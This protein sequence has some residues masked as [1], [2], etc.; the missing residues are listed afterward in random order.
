MEEFITLRVNEAIS[1]MMRKL[2]AFLASLKRL[3]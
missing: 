1:L 3:G 2:D